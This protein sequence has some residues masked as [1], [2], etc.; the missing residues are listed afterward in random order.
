MISAGTL[1]KVYIIITIILVIYVL[2]K[3]RKNEPKFCAP[4]EGFIYNDTDYGAFFGLGGYH[5]GSC[6]QNRNTYIDKYGYCKKCPV[7]QYY[8][9]TSCIY[10]PVGQRLN[11]NTYVCE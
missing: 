9:G 10:C 4:G 5:C 6:G 3:N 1:L 7:D 11:I 2:Y 8:D